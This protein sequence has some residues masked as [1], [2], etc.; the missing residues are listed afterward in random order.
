MDQAYLNPKYLW[1]S[2]TSSLC[3]EECENYNME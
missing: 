1:T 2:G 3:A